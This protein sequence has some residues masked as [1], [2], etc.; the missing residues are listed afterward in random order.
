MCIRDSVLGSPRGGGRRHFGQDYG[1]AE[2]TKVMAAFPGTVKYY[3]DTHGGGGWI[4]ELTHAD[5]PN[6]QLLYMH[7]TEATAQLKGRSVG[8]GEEIA[9]AGATGGNYK[10]HLHAEGRYGGRGGKRFNVTEFSEYNTGTLGQHGTLFKNF[11]AGTNAVLHNTEAVLTPQ[12]MNA[13]MNTGSNVATA[14]LLDS[15]DRNFQRL[16]IVMSERT[17]LSRSQLSYIEQQQVRIA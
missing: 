17:N 13:V 8:L 7:L 6:L 2:G 14:E 5:D 4:A 10:P 12:Q 1:V 9:K 15:I 16:A 3:Y 11:G